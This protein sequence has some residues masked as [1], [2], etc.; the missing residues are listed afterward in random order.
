[1]R[2][3]SKVAL[4]AGAG[5]L[6]NSFSS[7]D[8]VGNG[9]AC[10]IRFAREG[11]T[12]ICTDRS[13]PAARETVD[14]IRAEGGSAEA[15]ELDVTNSAQIDLA[16]EDVARRHGGIDILHNNVGI[17]IQGDLLAVQD[18][19]WDRVMTIN[20]RGS[21]AMARA[22]L[23]HMKSRGGG[24]II[25]VSSTASLKWS[26]MQFLS[27]S[28][29][30]AAVNHMT[31]VIARQY[32]AEQVRCNC[33]IP[34]MIRTPHADALYASEEAAAEGHKARD[35]RCPMGRQGSPWDIANAALFLASDEAAYVTGCLMVV[36]GGS[37][38]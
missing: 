37:S 17:E 22:F 20:V 1:M 21:M 31:R 8:S 34:G 4:V 7:M 16:S 3:K 30:K 25:N 23:P 24:S 10:A 19:D 35:A 13:L 29:A 15:L 5:T 27:Y 38:L 9:A 33:I 32:A 28:T 2:L 6:R 14:K 12:V 11:A 26:P 18:D 36:D